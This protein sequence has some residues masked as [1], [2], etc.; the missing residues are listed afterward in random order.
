MTSHPSRTHL[1]GLSLLSLVATSV[2]AQGVMTT[3]GQVVAS[4]GGTAAGLPGGVTFGSTSTGIFDTPTIAPNGSI[5][6]RARL[7]GGSVTTLN[8]RAL[9][10]GHS[11][12]DLRVILRAGDLE[13]TGTFPN[14]QV[15]QTGSTGAPLGSNTFATQR[16]TSSLVAPFQDIIMFQAQLYDPTGLDGL[17]NTGTAA[18][19][20]ILYYGTPVPGGMQI[21]AR[22][23]ITTMPDG[24]VL[25]PDGFSAQSTSLNTA[26]TAVFKTTI[27]TTLGTPTPPV[28]T[29]ND[30]AWVIGT[31]GTLNYVL[32][33]GDL[34]LS[35]VVG[36]GNI[37]FNCPLNQGG[38]VLLDPTLSTTLGSTPAT[39]SNDRMIAIWTSGV[40]TQVMR[41][42]DPAVDATGTPIP[43]VF[44][45]GPTL[46][47]G[48]TDTGK[49]SF[50]STMTGSVLPANDGAVFIGDTSLVTMVMREGDVAPGTGG[51]TIASINSTMGFSEAGLVVGV[52][53]VSP[54]IG[55]TPSNDSA[56][57]LCK[58]GQAPQLIARE[59]GAV[60]GIA[61]FNIGATGGAT[62]F[63]SSSQGRINDNGHIHIGSM[64]ITD[65][66]T[67]RAAAMS[68]HPVLGLQ[69]QLLENDVI[70]GVTVGFLA[71]NVL[72]FPSGDGGSPQGMNLDGDFVMTPQ[73]TT[74]NFV[75]RGKVATLVG[76]PSSVPVVGGVPHN[77]Q[78][79][80]GPT[81]GNLLYWVLATTQGTRPGFPSPLGPQNI[82][83]NFD[84][85]W[86]FLSINAANTPIWFN[87]VGITDA[88]GVGVGPSTFNMPLGFPMFLGETL[89]HAVMIF[90]LS[91]TSYYVSEPTVCRLY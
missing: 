64:P 68:Y 78:I 16:I 87:T 84:P 67:Q 53:L 59:G 20:Q 81:N 55:V 5:L 13:P 65:G 18:N 85:L 56:L 25:I 7:V 46:G 3:N 44:Y 4:I 76:T 42:G 75:V 11:S 15:L 14:S 47:Q 86:T 33:E 88:N 63:G 38:Q 79:N 73:N 39:T 51:E 71:G 23:A 80:V 91:L 58:Q 36:V 37:G 9:V 2:A 8:E 27:S 45:G 48:F 22:R 57:Y 24:S 17:T 35:G 62:N 77:F 30:T 74:A 1:L 32:R 52:T 60:P 40:L 66:T 29:G 12:G 49:C 6:V 54:G 41:E 70:G 89:H 61:G 43:G 26:G 83:L 10:L 82:P 28:T 19:N 72:Q 90:D 31:P 69:V 21:L 50:Q 34:I